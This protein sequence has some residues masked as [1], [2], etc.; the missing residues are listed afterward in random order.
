M[1]NTDLKPFKTFS[2]KPKSFLFT[3]TFKDF[4]TAQVAG[5]AV[6]GYMT[7]TYEQPVI[8][9]TYQGDGFN[10]LVIGYAE[11]KKLNYIFKRI[12]DSFKGYYHQPEDMTDEELDTLFQE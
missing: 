4:D 5:H 6:M 1:T 12:C 8:E 11:D 10:R 7:G 2:D 9:V 3:Y